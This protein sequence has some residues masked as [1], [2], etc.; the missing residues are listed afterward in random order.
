[1]TRLALALMALLM[2]YAALLDDATA[3][4]YCAAQHS[5]ATCNHILNR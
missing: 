4:R 5:P 3:R 1:M 2:A